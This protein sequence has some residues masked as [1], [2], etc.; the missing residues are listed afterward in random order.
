MRYRIPESTESTPQL[1]SKRGERRF[2]MGDT[3]MSDG[4]QSTAGPAINLSIE[5]I[6]K[7]TNLLNALKN[8][9]PETQQFLNDLMEG[10]NPS[11]EFRPITDTPINPAPKQTISPLP[12]EPIRLD[13]KFEKWDGNSLT[14]MPHYYLLKMQCKIYQPLLV[15]DEAICMKIYESIPEPKRQQIRG[16]WI[17]CGRNDYY[18]WKEMLEVC[19]E[20]FFDRI[21][22]QK[23]ERK[24]LAMR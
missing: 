13:A 6:N 24:L 3:E 16:Y 19:H 4:Q 8:A 9:P 1:S 7:V 22:A 11:T 20:E 23:A 10:K 18:D 17:K 14:W 5:D 2:I 12:T 21:E 15:T